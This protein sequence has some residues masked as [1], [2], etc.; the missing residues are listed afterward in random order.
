MTAE[1]LLKDDP[2]LAA[3]LFPTSLEPAPTRRTTTGGPGSAPWS[4]G[5]HY[6]GHRGISAVIG[7]SWP[8]TWMRPKD[9]SGAVAYR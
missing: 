4:P 5:L 1:Q 7:H 6:H 8:P 2:R 3:K 9:E